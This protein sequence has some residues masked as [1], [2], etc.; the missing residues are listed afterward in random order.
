[1]SGVHIINIENPSQRM[2]DAIPLMAKT[3]PIVPSAEELV[4]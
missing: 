1:M 3:K 4:L 2:G